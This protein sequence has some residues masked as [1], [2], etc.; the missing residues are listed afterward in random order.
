MKFRTVAI[1]GLGAVALSGWHHAGDIVVEE[2]VGITALR[3]VYYMAKVLTALFVG[4]FRRSVV[5]VEE[6]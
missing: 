1:A 2:G 4:L 5:P 3:S 6:A